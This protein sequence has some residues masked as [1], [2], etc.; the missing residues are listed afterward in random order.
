[1]R[2]WKA[3]NKREE[4]G[5]LILYHGFEIKKYLRTITYFSKVWQNGS[6]R[7]RQECIGFAKLGSNSQRNI[8]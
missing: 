4:N 5:F 1:M 6:L 3:F 2:L 7:F 8:M